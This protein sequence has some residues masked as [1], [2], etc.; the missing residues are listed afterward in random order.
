MAISETHLTDVGRQK[1][2]KELRATNPSFRFSGGAAVAPKSSSK[3]CTGGKHSGVGFV[4]QHP[5]RPV[6]GKWEEEAWQ[7]A[8]VHAAHVLVDGH[9]VTGGV[10]YGFSYQSWKATVKE[11]TNALLQQVADKVLS[12]PG[13]KFISG[14][15]NIE[16]AQCEFVQML[17]SL[18]WQDIQDLAMQRWQ[19]SPVPTCKGATRKDYMMLCP[20]MQER[21]ASCQVRNEIFPDHA[22][23]VAQI[24]KIGGIPMEPVWHK[25]HR[26]DIPKDH[27][28]AWKEQFLV[29]QDFCCTD[30]WNSPCLMTAGVKSDSLSNGGRAATQEIKY[31]PAQPITVKPS[32][33]GDPSLEASCPT[34]LLKSVF[35]QVR[36]LANLQ[37]VMQA[38]SKQPSP[39]RQ[40]HANSIWRAVVSASG[41]V[42]SFRRWWLMRPVTQEDDPILLPPFLPD[43]PVIQTLSGTMMKNLR[44]LEQLQMKKAQ[45]RHRKRLAA[46]V[47][48]I[49]RDVKDAGP[50]PVETLLTRHETVVIE[51]P[52]A[53]TVVVADSTHFDHGLPVMGDKHP[54]QLEVCSDNQLWFA[55][56]HSL[57][58]G[59][60][61]SQVEPIGNVDQMFELFIEAW[62][63]RWDKH[64]V[65]SADHWD[66][67]VQFLRIALPLKPMPVQPLTV[68]RWIDEVSRKPTRAAGGM[69]GV[70]RQDLALLPMK[71]QHQLV[72]LLNQVEQT[73]VW[74]KQLLHGAIF[75]LQ[76]TPQAE[77]VDGYRPI[78]ILPLVYRTWSSLRGR[79]MLQHL[80]SFLPGM[81]CGSAN[82][83]SA[84]TV[85]YAVQAHIEQAY[86]DDGNLCGAITD[87]TKAFNCLPR[88]PLIG[89]AVITGVADEII[90]PW[91]GLLTGLERHFMIRNQISRGVLSATGFAE[92]CCLSVG[93]ML[94]ANI[95]LHAYMTVAAPSVR[96]WSYIDNWE[97]T[98][99][100]P[101]SLRLGLQKLQS[102]AEH[103]DL[104]MDA[105]KAMVWA[106]TPDHRRQLR[107]DEVPVVMSTRDLGGHL[108]FSK[109][110]TSKTL[111]D[112][113]DAL[114][115]M[116]GR[117]GRSFAPRHL[118]HKVLRMKAWPSAL[119]ACPGVHVS[120]AVLTS[121]RASA[122]Q[123]LR[124]QKAGCN[125]SV[126]LGLCLH[127]M[128]DPECYAVMQCVVQIRR[129]IP[130]H[131]FSAYAGDVA[132]VPDRQRVPGPLG[133][134]F[135]RLE[136]LAWTWTGQDRWLDHLQHPV[137]LYDS[138]IQ[139]LRARILVSFQ[140]SVGSRISRRHGFEGMQMVDAHATG[141]ATQ[142]LDQE[143]L[144]LVRALHSG[145]FITA[146]QTG[147]AHRIDRT[148]WTCKFCG[149][150]DSLEH[151]HWQCSYTT[152]LRE[153]LSSEFLQWLEDQPPCT[154][155][156]GWTTIPDEV[157]QFQH[158]LL[159][160]RDTTD[161]FFVHGS[162]GRQY[163]FFTD[164]A[165]L[166][167]QQRMCRLASWAWCFSLPGMWDFRLGGMGG[168]P[169]R[170]QTVVRAEILAV[171]GVLQFC[172]AYNCGGTIVCDNDLVVKRLRALLSGRQI[173]EDNLCA[174]H[175][176]WQVAGALVSRLSVSVQV[177]HIYSHQQGGGDA[178]AIRWACRGNDF[179]DWYAQ[180]AVL[181]LPPDVQDLQKQAWFM[182][183]QQQKFAKVLLS[184]MG[185]VGSL[186]VAF[187]Q[188]P[189][190]ETSEETTKSETN[191]EPLA[192]QNIVQHVS[193]CV[194]YHFRK[195]GYEQWLSW[196][197]SIS[198]E[199]SPVRWVSWLE[200]LV[201]FQVATDRLGVICY[202][203]E[204]GNLRQ[205]QPVDDETTTNWP[206]LISSF[207]RYGNT[208]IRLTFPEWRACHR[209]PT[210]WRIKFWL[211]CIPVRM[212][213]GVIDVIEDYF[214]VH[215]IMGL[216]ST[217]DLIPFPFARP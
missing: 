197:A 169:G 166:A 97:L 18:G 32:R 186:S 142:H 70:T 124:L 26:I 118:K 55:Q 200:L 172:L 122:I 190:V 102:F 183:Q 205:W 67:I 17:R 158:S 56:E 111:L 34:R 84:M 96:L 61:I 141:Y 123:G 27:I 215:R 1:F 204:S 144:G 150:P 210:M 162:Q 126:Y 95:A 49:F 209:R 109:Q 16:P 33:H 105:K 106:I 171:V 140:A 137:S 86:L 75:S 77:S 188:G 112:K 71:Q 121:L 191:V 66:H 44:H 151:R 178:E 214:S 12:F 10:C 216:N 177:V 24:A 59:Q 41:F 73:G 138:C 19:I 136:K 164:G 206:A 147:Q 157:I 134:L 23:L 91:M 7:T 149:E 170:W 179:A 79:E 187:G 83:Q 129:W 29:K 62:K 173:A 51:V 130:E 181:R 119:H 217:K 5:C 159:Q 198:D 46:D 4:T 25:P 180:Q 35:L 20:M 165:A 28:A 37:R 161:Q 154:R 131:V 201:H 90:R 193:G 143:E 99:P 108:Q 195:S 189:T 94:L 14:D 22:V 88:I 57:L 133:V 128:H 9:W 76:K 11:A 160:I 107:Q 184:Y 152:S 81:L 139:E 114:M 43:L 58:I 2:Q 85:W 60:T 203:G 194:P 31:R 116:W 182:V 185:K 82:H 93:A 207:G 153:D 64:R 110:L 50:M 3:F 65:V 208:L 36:R 63:K 39:S 30:S 100:H 40:Q 117:L 192:V 113:C 54:L 125:A 74:P 101:E 202:K 115:P 69:D 72:E 103:L 38:N 68:D 132:F 47:H 146:D 127:P 53:G 48:S 52:D 145:T 80:Q 104:T 8:R 174:D 168:V 196:F 98:C 163:C 21:V 212:P 175:D 148:K 6:G 42:P 45:D 87:V 176:L 92:G 15:W 120:D 199:E 78:T 156:R 13:P 135:D 211:S 213:K 89:A 167:P 155:L